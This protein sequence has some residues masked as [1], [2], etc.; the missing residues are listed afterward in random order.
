MGKIAPLYQNVRLFCA[1]TSD[2]HIDIKHP[3]PDV[4]AMSEF[5]RQ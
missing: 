5:G 1:V 3:V 4:P 2:N